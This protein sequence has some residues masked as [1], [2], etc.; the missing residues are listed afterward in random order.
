M[1]EAID[2]LAKDFKDYNF[3][4]AGDINSF[5]EFSTKGIDFYPKNK[6]DFTTLK[7]RTAS[8]AQFHKAEKEIK[9]SK[10]K[11]ISSLPLEKCKVTFING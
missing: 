5:I 7:K 11:I 2:V 10:D 6:D 8:Q 3:V 1:K 9:E 4:V